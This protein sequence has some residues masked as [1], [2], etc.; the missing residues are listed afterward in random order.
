MIPKEA[1][2][3]FPTGGNCKQLKFE[4]KGVACEALLAQQLVRIVNTRLRMR[5]GQVDN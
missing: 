5:E 1:V 4:Q 3:D 2:E